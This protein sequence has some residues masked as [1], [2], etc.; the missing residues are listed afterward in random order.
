MR[1]E[2]SEILFELAISMQGTREGFSLA[3]ICVRY[4]VSRRTAERMRD[5]IERIFPQTEQANPGEIPKRWRIPSGTLNRLIGFSAE[6]LAHLQT[7]ILFLKKEN[8]GLQAHTLDGIYS[9]LG[10]L[11][12]DSMTARVEPDLETLMLS[13]GFAMRPGPRPDIDE[14]IIFDLLEAIKG[15]QKVRLYYHSRDTGK[16]SRQVVCPYG[17][18]YGHRH[19]LVAYSMNPQVRD[20][21]MFSLSNIKRIESTGWPFERRDEFSLAEYTERSFGVFQEEPFN[22]VWK[23]SPQ[24]APDAREFQFH[25]TQTI[26][27][28]ADGSLIVRFKA[29][30]ALEMSWHLL[31]WG[32]EVKVLEPK[33]FWQKLGWEH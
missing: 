29:G 10:S 8:L 21:R 4:S 22:V 2:K 9:K 28:Q 27:D 24:A 18:L 7:A 20:Y 1:F 23:F 33:N 11:L 6:E 30:G 3:D 5:A 26:E 14:L 12:S 15:S 25:P 32:D 19:Y 16:L 17:F 31:T 13:A